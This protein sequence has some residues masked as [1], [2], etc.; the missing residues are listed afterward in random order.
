MKL[1]NNTIVI[2]GGATGIGLELARRL[3]ELNNVVIIC[4]RSEKK[5]YQAKSMYPKLDFHCC[6]VSDPAS[7]KTFMVWLE[8]SHPASN[9]LIN[10]AAMVHKTQFFE[11]REMESKAEIEIKTN[12]LGPIVMSK[13]FHNRFGH[14][15]D[16]NLIN[17][18]TGLV[19]APKKTYPIYNACKSALHSFTQTLRL[20][21]A[22]HDIKIKEILLPVVDTPWHQGT[23]PKMA[24]SAYTAVQEII[25]E[26][27]TGKE[28]I[29]IGKVK[30]L[31]WLHRIAPFLAIKRI[32]KTA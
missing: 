23:V 5:L 12:L 9:V 29:K 27:K 21:E 13:Q 3:L 30:L 28:E 18:T 7:I 1:S 32:N 24:I 26:L 20:Q 8:K 22:H 25:K 2:T 14:N 31:Y 17:I 15:P 19:Y 4:S 16:C 10:N 11:D 6:D